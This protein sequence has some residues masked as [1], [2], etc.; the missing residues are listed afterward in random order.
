MRNGGRLIGKPQIGWEE[1]VRNELPVARARDNDIRL[2]SPIHGPC[3]RAVEQISPMAECGIRMHKSPAFKL[4]SFHERPALK[5]RNT[6]QQNGQ[7]PF[8]QARVTR[9]TKIILWKSPILEKT[10]KA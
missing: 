6:Q 4:L 8:L 7:S 9:R 3:G 5:L 10:K 2:K 1:T